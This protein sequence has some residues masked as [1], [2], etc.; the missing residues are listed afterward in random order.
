MSALAEEA[1]E[2]DVAVIPA[3]LRLAQSGLPDGVVSLN[4]RRA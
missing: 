3:H 4:R 2:R 1:A